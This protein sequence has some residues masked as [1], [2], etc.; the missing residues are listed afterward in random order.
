MSYYTSCKI[1]KGTYRIKDNII[2]YLKNMKWHCIKN[3][4][5]YILIYK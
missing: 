4:C 5:F 2:K 3:V 1:F